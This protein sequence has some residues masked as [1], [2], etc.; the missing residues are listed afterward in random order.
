LIT[1]EQAGGS[2]SQQAALKIIGAGYIYISNFDKLIQYRSSCF[3]NRAAN[4]C[5]HITIGQLR[6]RDPRRTTPKPPF[7]KL[8]ASPVFS[9]NR[10]SDF[11]YVW[12]FRFDVES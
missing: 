8:A 11:R 1:E 4:T 7:I 6:C 5:R 12:M 2:D 9:K 10:S 3:S